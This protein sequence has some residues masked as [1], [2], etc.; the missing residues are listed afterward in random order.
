MSNQLIKAEI[1]SV[2]SGLLRARLTA[3]VKKASSFLVVSSLGASN[4]RSRAELRSSSEGST[5]Y[6]IKL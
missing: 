4:K 2:C 6:S 1:L 5:D 3:L